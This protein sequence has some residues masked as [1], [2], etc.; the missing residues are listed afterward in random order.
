MGLA[1]A[2]GAE[3]DQVV[4][5]LGVR[6]QADQLADLAAPA[7]EVGVEAD[8]LDEQVDPFRGGEVAAGGQV[9]VEI[10][11]GELDGLEG[12]QDPGRGVLVLAEQVLQVGDAPDPAHQQFGVGL[13]GGGVDEDLLDAQVAEFRLVGVGL[14][15]E[16]DADAVDDLVA[17][18]LPD[19]GADQARLVAV[20]VVLAQDL[21]DRVDAALDARLVVGGAVL[22]E[23]VLQDIG[24]HDG[25]ALDGLDQVLAHHQ[26]GEVL[27][28]LIVE[29]AHGGYLAG[30]RNQ[31]HW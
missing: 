1:G 9:G 10:E 6:H 30:L 7:E 24:G 18:P 12:G 26:A 22:A 19:G 21:L 28:D 4:V 17:P 29:G 11:M 8:A 20:D 14:V 5:A 27:I 16:G 3:F 13:D 2:L 25:V 23:Q 31:I 15:V